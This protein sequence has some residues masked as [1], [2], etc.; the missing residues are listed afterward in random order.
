MEQKTRDQPTAGTQ[1]VAQDMSIP[2]ERS[3][4]GAFLA[5]TSATQNI[6][7]EVKIRIRGK[8]PPVKKAERKPQLKPRKRKEPKEKDQAKVK[9]PV[10]ILNEILEGIG[11][12][13]KEGLT[14]TRKGAEDI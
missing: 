12:R 4:G 14:L 2:V 6:K 3:N 1:S 9:G 11:W 5:N 7:T 10:A 13:R 8:R